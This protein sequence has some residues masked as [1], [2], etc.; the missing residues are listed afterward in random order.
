MSSRVKAV[1]VLNMAPPLT[2]IL[3]IIKTILKPK[4]FERVSMNPRNYVFIFTFLKICV[5]SNEDALK[6]VIP[7]NLLPTDYGGEGLSLQ[8]L[9]GKFW[10]KNY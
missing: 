6:K 2:K 1:H 4:I 10:K 8:K 3:Q 9:E 5:H 7:L